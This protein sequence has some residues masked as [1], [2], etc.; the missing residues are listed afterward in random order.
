[1]VQLDI[2]QKAAIYGEA[3]SQSGH[4]INVARRQSLLFLERLLKK[5]GLSER[6]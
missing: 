5:A 3:S 1:M 2:D 4:L 6:L